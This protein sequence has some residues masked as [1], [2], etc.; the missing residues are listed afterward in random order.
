MVLI[1]HRTSIVVRSM[2]FPTAPFV[3]LK[4]QAETLFRLICCERET[5]FRLKKSLKRRIIREAN[6]AYA[7]NLVYEKC[8]DGSARDKGG[9][10]W[11]HKNI[12]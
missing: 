4:K 3:S 11:V 7:M 8:P 2:G 5:L 9:V 10:N 12:T 6:R 1:R